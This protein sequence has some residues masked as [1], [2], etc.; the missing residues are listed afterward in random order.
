MKIFFIRHGQT[1][2][3]KEG[4]F[5][6]SKDSPLTEEGIFQAEKLRDKL[7]KENFSFNKVYSSPLGRAF[8]T[9]KIITNNNYDIET[10]EHFKEISV[11]EMEGVPFEEFK[12]K[13]PTEYHDFFY[14]PYKYNPKNIKGESFL[15][16][17]TRIKEGLD[18]ITT[19]NPPN[20]QILVVTHGIT[21]R[22]ILSYISKG[23]LD[24][25]NFSD[26]PVPENTSVTTIQFKNQKFS[27]LDFSNI[28]HL[29]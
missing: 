14:K 24:L 21:L 9:T 20:S 7:L 22:G 12:Q 16:L 25:E 26:T 29:K 11:G 6:G 1:L 4:K 2:W 10:L 8:S 18:K 17:M 13:F 19:E 15:S 5:Q 28:E 23:T 3:N 27:I